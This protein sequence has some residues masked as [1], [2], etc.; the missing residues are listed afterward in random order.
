MKKILL[1]SG[2]G[3]ADCGAVSNINGVAYREAD[4]TRRMTAAVAEYLEGLADVTVYP[5]DRNAYEDYRKGTLHTVA[6]FRAYDYVLEIHFNAFTAGAADGKIKGTEIFWVIDKDKAS[7]IL[8]SVVRLGFTNRGVKT[9]SLAVINAAK[10]KGTAAAL[11]EVC[12]I[13][14]PDDMALYT[15]DRAAVARAI[16]GGLTKALELTKKE[17]EEMLIY[18]QWK[19]YMERYREELGDKPV[20]P[21]AADSVAKAQAEGITDGT[22]PGDL[23]TRQEAVTMIIRATKE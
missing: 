10:S 19:A 5:T 16:A 3:A 1:I 7:T 22:R 8:D 20:S 12:F 23:V 11:L 18:E 13:D 4:E 21:W 2:H 9:Q 17:D 6:N 15:R 14:D